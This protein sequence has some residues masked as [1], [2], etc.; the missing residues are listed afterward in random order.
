ME[1]FLERLDAICQKNESLLCVGLDPDPRQMPDS[2]KDVASFNKAIVD[3]THDLVCAFKPNLAFYEALGIPG[4]E[5]LKATVEYIRQK[6][7]GVVII[8][9]AKRGDVGN[10]AEAYAR[11]MF[12]TWC[13]DAATVNTYG[14]LD[15]LQPFMRYPGRCILLWCR[16]SNP[17][18]GDLQDLKVG[19][20]GRDVPLYQH[21]AWLSTKLG[22]QTQVGLVVG[23][24]YPREMEIVRRVCPSAPILVP[25][26]GAQRG[27]LQASVSNGVDARGRRAIFSSSRQVIYAS[28]G[29]DFAQKARDAAMRIKEQ[30][31]AVLARE[32][33]GW[34]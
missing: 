11:A 17:G 31:N 8:A 34:S 10:T 33:K 21:V 7:P 27:G 30:I 29:S 9:D 16:S 15:T 23:A 4:F 22:G 25:G 28:R 26:I 13:F 5:A 3:A 12:E 24:T 19:S 1:S 20:N 6:A 18:A 14:G 32:G 2:F